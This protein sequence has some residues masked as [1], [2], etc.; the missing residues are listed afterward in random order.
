M[1]AGVDTFNYL[2]ALSV[3]LVVLAASVL[4]SVADLTQRRHPYLVVLTVVSV[5]LTAGL[6]FSG[7]TLVIVV[8][9]FVAPTSVTSRP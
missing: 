8:A 2:V 5:I 9:L 3:L 6:D 4:R 1:G 7:G